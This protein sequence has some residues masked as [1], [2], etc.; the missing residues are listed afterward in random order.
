MNT[1]LCKKEEVE[2]EGEAK[3]RHDR[4]REE[5]GGTYF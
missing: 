5:G 3:K 4:Y 1:M 2:T